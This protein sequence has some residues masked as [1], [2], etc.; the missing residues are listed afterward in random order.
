MLWLLWKEL[1]KNSE[2]FSFSLKM[3]IKFKIISGRARMPIRV[4]VDQLD[5]IYFQHKILKEN[6]I[7][8]K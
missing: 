6:Q 2:I 3:K 7:V 5:M 1:E 8:L 4:I